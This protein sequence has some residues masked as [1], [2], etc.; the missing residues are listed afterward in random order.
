MSNFKRGKMLWLVPLIVAV[1]Y[2]MFWGIWSLAT[3]SVPVVGRDLLTRDMLIKLPFA[4]SRWWDVLCVAISAFLFIRFLLYLKEDS[5]EAKSLGRDIDLDDPTDTDSKISIFAILFGN[6]SIGLACSGAYLALHHRDGTFWP[7]LF[8][9]IIGL[10]LALFQCRVHVIGFGLGFGLLCSQVYGLIFC[11]LLIF[12]ITPIGQ[13]L[14]LN[15]FY[16]N[17]IDRA[18]GLDG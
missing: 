8:P 17:A 14:K 1:I 7:I 3:G 18:A 16:W 4:V 15:N 10:F 11:L 2:A 13:R 5:I 12:I 9:I 6:A